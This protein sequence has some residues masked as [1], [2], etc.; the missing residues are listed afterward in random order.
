[1]GRLK[2]FHKHKWVEIERFYAEGIN[3]KK[4]SSGGYDLDE[5]HKMA[6]GL[7]TIIYRCSACL[8]M[9]T[10]EILGKSMKE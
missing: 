8:K 4:I 1:M 5:F 10:E 9:R 2:M 3:I 7:T 6:S